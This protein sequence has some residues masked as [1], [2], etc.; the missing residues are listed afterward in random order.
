MK[1]ID[2]NLLPGE[3]ILYSGKLHWF[4]FAPGIALIVAGIVL[5]F[6]GVDSGFVVLMPLAFIAGVGSLISA[7][8]KQVATELAVTSK[9]IIAKT[10]LIRRHTIELNLGKVESL[11]VAQSVSGR[12][13]GFGNISFS[14]TGGAVNLVATIDDPLAFRRAAMQAIDAVQAGASPPD[15]SGVRIRERTPAADGG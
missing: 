5:V 12:L 7:G 11:S 3:S 15:V 2:S 1:Y 8:I 10:G 9:R 6:V 14:G 13:F 4:I